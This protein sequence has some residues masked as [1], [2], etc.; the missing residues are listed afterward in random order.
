MDHQTT[1][2]QVILIDTGPPK[3]RGRSTRLL[4]GRQNSSYMGSICIYSKR[5]GYDSST[6]TSFF[7]G[8]TLPNH[9][10]RDQPVGWK[11]PSQKESSLPTI[12]RAICWSPCVQ[13]KRDSKGLRH[14]RLLD[15]F[16]SRRLGSSHPPDVVS[17]CLKGA[18]KVKIDKGP[19]IWPLV[20]QYY[21]Q[22][23]DV[24]VMCK[25]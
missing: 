4:K 10:T 2:T 21:T 15:I 11:A 7:G 13:K 12:F 6:K 20:G 25:K 22:G 5:F 8:I 3:P 16:D 1:R 17:K 24:I 19:F 9:V 14:P 18:T 23:I